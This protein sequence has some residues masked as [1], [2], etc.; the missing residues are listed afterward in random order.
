MVV[1]ESFPVPESIESQELESGDAGFG[2]QSSGSRY[3]DGLSLQ[4]RRHTP[5]SPFF[6]HQ[7]F[8]TGP[9]PCDWTVSGH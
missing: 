5:P 4:T 1:P 2:G 6:Q 3:G 8:F 9:Q 7:R